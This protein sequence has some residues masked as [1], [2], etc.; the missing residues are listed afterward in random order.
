MT[1]SLFVVV[2]R[3]IQTQLITFILERKLSN[4]NCF[5]TKKNKN[6]PTLASEIFNDQNNTTYIICRYEILHLFSH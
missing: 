1:T 2:H 5:N 4:S 6:K 3:E